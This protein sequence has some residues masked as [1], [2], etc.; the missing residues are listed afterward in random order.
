MEGH[1]IA[2][3]NVLTNT[4]SMQRRKL[5]KKKVWVG[6][7]VFLTLLVAS[8]STVILLYEKILWQ[9]NFLKFML[10]L[11]D[12]NCKVRYLKVHVSCLN[13]KDSSKY[14]VSILS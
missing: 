4:A 11:S 5:K 6:N 7:F 2:L 10:V 8:K 3:S 1:E 9:L 12:L 14:F 13:L